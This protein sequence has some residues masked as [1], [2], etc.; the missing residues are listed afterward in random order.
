MEFCRK[1]V[2]VR[3]F[4][5]KRTSQGVAT[6][7]PVRQPIPRTV[8][9]RV[10]SEN[11][12]PVKHERSRFKMTLVFQMA[13]DGFLNGQKSL[14]TR[15]YSL[16]WAR[17]GSVRRGQMFAQWSVTQSW[18]ER[19]TMYITPRFVLTTAIV[20]GA[21]LLSGCARDSETRRQEFLA[22]GTSYFERQQ[23]AEAAIQ[24]RN[25][26]QIDAGFAPARLGLARAHEQMGKTEEALFQYIRAADLLP[27]DLE[28]Q[29]LVGSYLLAAG[30]FDDARVRA[31]AV[32]RQDGRNVR[33]HL[34]LGNALA[35]VREMDQ[36]MAQIEGALRIDPMNAATHTNLGMLETGRGRMREA[37]AA[38]DRAIE[39]E[40]ESVPGHLARA[41]HYW[42]T[43]RPADAE[44]ALR[45]AYD[46]EPANP[47]T[48]RA[49]V[50]LLGS[51][52]RAVDA[53]PYVRALASSGAEPF[54]LADFY[55]LQNRAVDA[56]PPLQQLRA[57]PATATEAGRRL[58]HAYG[59]RKD[60]DEADRVIGELLL[61]NAND[62]ETLLL[63]GQLLATRGRR[64]EAH[65]LFQKVAQI[66]PS[67]VPLQFAL[68]RSYAARGDVDGARRGFNEA[69]RLNPRA[70]AAQV[71]LARLELA[72][73]RPANSVEFARE[74]VRN[75]PANF[76]AQL[77]LVRGL[78]GAKDVEGAR[79]VLDPLLTAHP[80]RAAL[81]T[82]RA[83]ALAAVNDRVGARRSFNR[84]LELDP[85]SLETLEGLLALDTSSGDLAAARARADRALI[86]NPDNADV[87]LIAARTYAAAR[88]LPAAE[89]SV[90]RALEI[91]PN[92][93]PGY[94]M[95]GQ[96]Y[97]LQG[98][99]ADARREFETLA[100]REARPVAA[101][102]ILGMF[103]MMEGNAAQAQE[104]FE[105]AIDLDPRA[106][107][108]AN[109]LA[110]M[111]A[112]RGEK[113][114]LALQ[115]AGIAV[116]EL[117]KASEVR[118]TL[119]WVQYKRQR[120]DEAIYAFREAIELSPAD[121]TY[122]YHLGLAY[123]LAGKP[124]EA[125]TAIER[126]LRLGG[127]TLPWAVEAQSVLH[128]L[129]PAP[130]HTGSL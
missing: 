54:A 21:A 97:L 19:S 125:R 14:G 71:E 129:A 40:P 60:L 130:E 119:G 66:D 53:E 111:Y 99:L 39:L 11:S 45:T 13:A 80:D 72:I 94:T 62:S 127:A 26:L 96:V 64:D 27:A 116:A 49:L 81:H 128:S 109:N 20:V 31:E 122:Q 126:A 67:S 34:I 90:R 73:G 98:R 12:W 92:L 35:G 5:V 48:N 68:G 33:A 114:D 61:K 9:L 117:P 47:I 106:P 6:H 38:F 29:L 23:Y 75:E 50:L 118:H 86:A 101:L 85:D 52:N 103:A 102:T 95:L 41:N 46:L 15:H 120:A 91:E 70:A 8:S 55:L 77:S 83:L 121:P 37:E 2:Y 28:L 56:I 25:A 100:R 51:T 65:A 17:C 93:L 88:D 10:G 3:R 42:T 24:Y 79:R 22:S 76:E 89:R 78:L 44:R 16:R 58:A 74:A 32:L 59:M 82:Q 84:A 18:I 1:D 110:W 123:V 108:A 105:R 69:L 113:L 87:W 4:R 107:V 43:G 115:L 36:A 57:A 30:S 7:Y 124:K 63:K 104:H 112:E